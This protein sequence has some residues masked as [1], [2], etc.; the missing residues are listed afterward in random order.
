LK[1]EDNLKEAL[2]AGIDIERYWA[3]TPKEIVLQLEAFRWRQSQNHNQ[4]AWAAWHIVALN[5]QKKI[6]ALKKLL[7]KDTQNKK[8]QTVDEQIKIAKFITSM[9]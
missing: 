7:I 2:K 3:S 4:L 5:R 8:F 6:P 1:W 9:Y